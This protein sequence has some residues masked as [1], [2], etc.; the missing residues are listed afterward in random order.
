MT[1]R[2][3]LPT[4]ARMQVFTS[5]FNSDDSCLVCAPTGSGK[6][7]CAELALMR[8]LGKELAT[9]GGAGF[10]GGEGG[11]KP[12]V[13]AVYVAPLEALVAERYDDWSV[14]LGEGLGVRVARLTGAH[15]HGHP[16]L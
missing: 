1:D 16:L 9:R 4:S 10:A 2:S 6:T 15:Q 5:L 12:T 3:H 7:V 14:R 11:G 13:H 8:L